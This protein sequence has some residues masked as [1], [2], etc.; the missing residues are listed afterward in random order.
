MTYKKY[1]HDYL[2][3]AS[4]GLAATSLALLLFVPTLDNIDPYLQDISIYSFV[5][6]L[7]FLTFATALSKEIRLLNQSSDRTHHYH[8]LL[9]IFGS[10]IFLLGIV[11][12][13][14]AMRFG[15]MLCFLFAFSV[16]VFI[17]GRAARA[18]IRPS[19]KDKTDRELREI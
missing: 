1:I 18:I 13:C 11:T 19:N 15:L 3:W 5:A 16:A 14:W 12:L 2:E 10:I 6:A 17:Y 8:G 4:G 9:V 7:P